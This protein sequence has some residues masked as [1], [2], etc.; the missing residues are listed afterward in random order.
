MNIRSRE[1]PVALVRDT[2]TAALCMVPPVQVATDVQVPPEP[3]TV[4]PSA[5]VLLRTMP[6]TAPFD[7]MLRNV[8]PLAPM[9]VFATFRA[10]PVVVVSVLMMVVLSWVALTV[11]P[12]VAVNAAV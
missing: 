4:R 2:P 7:E 11:P 3:D 1:T 10:V 6:F 9:V 8:K 5:P 12:P